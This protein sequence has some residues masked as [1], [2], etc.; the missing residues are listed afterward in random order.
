M[1]L[2]GYIKSLRKFRYLHRYAGLFIASLLFISAI[3]GILLAL[4]KDV[5]IIQAPTQKG[6]SKNMAEW[7]PLYELS[8][9]A[10]QALHQKHPEQVGNKVDRLD[11]RPSKGVVKVLFDK[12][13]WEVQIDAQ[14]GVVKSISRR[15]SDWIEAIHDGS[16]ISHIF[17]LISMHILGIGVLFIILSGLWLW[18]G[19]KRIKAIKRKRRKKI[20]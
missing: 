5:D 13:Y 17:K 1:L 8:A 14:S 2:K 12:G 6:Q 10:E 7:K 15:H 16:I 4:K 19:P 20:D 11:A 3:T 9:L 18:L